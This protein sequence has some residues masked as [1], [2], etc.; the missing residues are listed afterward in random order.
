MASENSASMTSVPELNVDSS[1][2]DVGAERLLE[3]PGLD[4]DDRR[5][6]GDVREVAEAQ[7]GRLSAGAASPPCA[8]G[9]VV[10]AASAEPSSSPSLP[11]AATT[12][13]EAGERSGQASDS[14]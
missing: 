2:V 8:S 13:H 6:V 10:G 12:Q 1:S 5:G 7:R 14:F 4:A 3:E 9:A 11:H